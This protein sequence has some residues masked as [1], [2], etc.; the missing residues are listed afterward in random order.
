MRDYAVKRYAAF[1]TIF[2]TAIRAA[3]LLILIAAMS[4][5]AVAAIRRYVI[6]RY[7]LILMP[8]ARFTRHAHTV[9]H[10]LCSAH[11]A[12]ASYCRRRRHADE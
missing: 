8:E 1:F 7:L 2:A 4:A 9:T 5:D 3:R 11:S 6:L 10:A 12:A